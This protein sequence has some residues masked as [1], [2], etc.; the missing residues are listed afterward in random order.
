MLAKERRIIER[1]MNRL[2]DVV[3]LG[4][5]GLRERHK[6]EEQIRLL[7]NSKEFLDFLARADR[8]SGF[9]DKVLG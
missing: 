3:S 1:D 8:R 5:C 9:F 2:G 4:A 7:Y 6:E